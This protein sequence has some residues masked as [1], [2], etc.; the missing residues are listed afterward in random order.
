MSDPELSLTGFCIPLREPFRGVAERKGI[1]IEGESGWG[2]YSPF[3]GYS[4]G[5]EQWAWNAAVSCAGRP[6]PTPV[7]DSVQVHVTLGEVSPE[8]AAGIVASSGCSAAKVKV[9][10]PG[11]EA[12]VEAVRDA[13]GPGGRLIVDAN[14]AW[15]LDLAVARIRRLGRFH[16]D[17]VEQPVAT[18]DEMR[19][20][21]RMVDVPLAADECM[22]TPADAE[23]LAKIEAADVLVL[24][25]QNMGGIDPCLLAVERSGLPAIVSSL[26]ETSVGLAAGLY[27]AA[28][29]PELPFPCGLGT[30]GL[31]KG[32]VVTD[33][34]VPN[35]GF[36]EVRRPPVNPALLRR[37]RS[38]SPE[39]IPVLS[40][41]APGR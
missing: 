17:L 9:G 2:E 34:L 10:Y 14:G 18:P 28:A 21:R 33:S 16:L 30:A 22:Q 36:I 7:R 19:I 13:L 35:E 25:V 37:F 39:E 6:W 24:K 3:P 20:L 29:L 38:N 12:R 40:P 27:L 32:D 5:N 4:D 11:D 1:L 15:D 8:R 26:I 41:P 23:H 31:L